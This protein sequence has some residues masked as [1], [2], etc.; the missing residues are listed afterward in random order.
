MTS[1]RSALYQ[2][3][4]HRKG[5]TGSQTQRLVSREKNPREAPTS[6]PNSAVNTGDRQLAIEIV[7]LLRGSR[8]KAAFKVNSLI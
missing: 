2:A 6:A 3:G 1:R 7:P 4:F 8:N 5:S